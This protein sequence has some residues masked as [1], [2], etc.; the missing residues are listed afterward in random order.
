MDEPGYWKLL[1][2]RKMVNQK[3]GALVEQ[4]PVKPIFDFDLIKQEIDRE[5]S[6][7]DPQLE[8]RALKYF[9]RA[10]E[11]APALEFRAN[12]DPEMSELVR[13]KLK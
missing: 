10:L 3:T 12:L 1:V 8:K 4:K 13:R 9:E 6:Q 5:V 7:Y 2:D 11:L